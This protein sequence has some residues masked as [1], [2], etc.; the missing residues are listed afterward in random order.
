LAIVAE[1][2]EYSKCFLYNFYLKE[3][4]NLS[5][6]MLEKTSEVARRGAEQ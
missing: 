2:E 1:R 4:E 5:R 6:F 3:K